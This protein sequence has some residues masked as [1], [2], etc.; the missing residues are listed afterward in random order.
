MQLQ[1]TSHPPGTET[2]AFPL[3]L[4]A[5]LHRNFLLVVFEDV[6]IETFTGGCADLNHLGCLGMVSPHLLSIQSLLQLC[7]KGSPQLDLSSRTVWGMAFHARD[8]F[9]PYHTSFF[10][11]KSVGGARCLYQKWASEILSSITKTECMSK[12]SKISS[13]L[14][15]L[16]L[17]LPSTF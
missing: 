14:Q 13:D 9:M 1:L 4:Q 17:H 2:F 6:R 12:K 15:I 16:E 7:H 10:P 11:K 3:G 8:L 5:Y